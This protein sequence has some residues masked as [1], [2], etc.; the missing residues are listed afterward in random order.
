MFKSTSPLIAL[1]PTRALL[2]TSKREQVTQGLS[3]HYEATCLSTGIWTPNYNCEPV[4][5]GPP[6]IPEDGILQLVGSD[7]P[8]TL[9]KDQVQFNCSSKYYTLEG[10]VFQTHT[11]AVPVVNGYQLTAITRCRY[12]L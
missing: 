4:D 3:T 6:G 1:A 7:N 8:Q 12:A 5:C 2:S 11:L 9:Y 10:E